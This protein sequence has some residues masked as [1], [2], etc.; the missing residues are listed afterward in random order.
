VDIL[1]RNKDTWLDIM[2]AEELGLL[3]TD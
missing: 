2:M 3:V 1:E